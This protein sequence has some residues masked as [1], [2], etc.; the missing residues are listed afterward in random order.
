MPCSNAEIGLL[1]G[2]NVHEA[3]EPWEV[4]HS[5]NNGPYA[6]ETVLGWTVNGPFR[7]HYGSGAEEQHQVTV[8][9]IS[10]DTVERLLLQQYNADFPEHL[11]SD[12]LEMSQQDKQF[13]GSVSSSVHHT[14]GHYYINLPIKESVVSLP[15]N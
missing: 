15:N 1:I 7:E 12:E 5:Q 2:N 8:N 14:N 3:F 4:I 13:L 11:C 9:C 10:V 6:V